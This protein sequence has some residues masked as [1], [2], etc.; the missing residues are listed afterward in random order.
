MFIGIFPILVPQFVSDNDHATQNELF[1]NSKNGRQYDTAFER[2]GNRVE[3]VLFTGLGS[4]VS[5]NFLPA[6]F[7]KSLVA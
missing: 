7:Q 6:L 1:Q 5:G 4:A 3:Y 2:N